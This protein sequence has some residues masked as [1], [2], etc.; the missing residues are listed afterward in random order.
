MREILVYAPV[1]AL[2]SIL[3]TLVFAIKLVKLWSQPGVFCKGFPFF[4]PSC[5]PSRKE[6]QGPG[7]CGNC[8]PSQSR[9][10]EPE[11]PLGFLGAGARITGLALRKGFSKPT[12]L[13]LPLPSTLTDHLGDASRVRACVRASTSI[14]LANRLVITSHGT[15]TVG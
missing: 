14:V 1:F 5:L 2:I 3:I 11:V 4:L 9:T 7:L 13:A 10:P 8:L 6:A 12:G 15:R